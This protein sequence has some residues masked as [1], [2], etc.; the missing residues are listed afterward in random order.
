MYIDP[1]LNWNYNTKILASKL[2]RSIGMLS[3]IRHYVNN[4]TLRSI[5]F[6]IFSSHLSYGSIIWAQNP[7]NQNVKRIS[8]LQ[9]R[10]LR[11][12]CFAD[13]RVHANPLYKH[14]N[15]LKFN[16]NVKMNNML[17]VY[18]SL[19]NSLPAILN[20]IYTHSKDIHEHNTRCSS[21]QK[22]SLPKV[23]TTT[24]GLIVLNTNV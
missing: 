20:N 15:I 6:A 12:I 3:K 11:V 1:N 22:L 23:E 24:H 9:N 13:Y 2:S 5:Y 4:E 14:Q 21:N 10:A 18:D 8:R 7:N 19:N 16:D 17:L